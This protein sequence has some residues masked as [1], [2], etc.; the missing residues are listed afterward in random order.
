MQIL[1][2]TDPAV[3]NEACAALSR[4]ELVIYPTET[5]YGLA[6]DAKNPEAV[7]RLLAYK[8][9]RHRQVAVAVNSRELA[10][11]Y[12]KI[13]ALADNLYK[14]FLPG[15]LTVISHSLHNLDN[16]LESADGKLG[17]RLPKHDFALS[18]IT[19]FGSPITATSANTSGKKEPYS[20]TDWQTYTIK[21][22]QELV[23]LFLDDGKLE[24]RPTS[25]VIDTTLN[26]PLILRQGE[27]V[28]PASAS[29]FTSN[30][31]TS[32][33]NFAKELLHKHLNL[34]RRF[35]L[36]IALQGNL[37]TGKTV[38]S[39]G[40]AAELGVRDTVSSPTYTLMKE[41]AYS[42]PKQSGTLYHLDTWR[43]ADPTEVE[44]TL[45]LS[46]LL[47]PGNIVIIEWAGKAQSLIKE[48]QNDT[49]ILLINLEEL[50]GNTRKISYNLS[51]PEWT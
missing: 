20:F 16:R 32:T 29:T 35:P 44:S 51:N 9:D 7:S 28:L 42:T 33:A 23:S 41:Y 21:S 22:K 50:G 19:A 49:A 10:T 1:K 12:V 34:L 11:Q 36:L 17:I 43:L 26:D 2:T 14:N 15:P 45:H 4:G 3:L 18:L 39:K 48:H 46:N 13:N 6:V 24:E 47:Q 38:M 27:F 8:G 31:P 37:G 25:T 40:F 5:C 30:S